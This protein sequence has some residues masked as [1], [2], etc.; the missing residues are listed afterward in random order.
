MRV[1]LSLA[2]AVAHSLSMTLATQPVHYWRFENTSAP[3]IDAQGTCDLTNGLKDYAPQSQDQDNNSVGNFIVFNYAERHLNAT[4]PGAWQ[5][6]GC[7]NDSPQGANGLTIEFLLHP[8]PWCFMRGGTMDL[9]RS[10]GGSVSVSMTYGGLSF[11]AATT[12]ATASPTH[13]VSFSGAGTL[14]SDHLWNYESTAGR[15][16]HFALARDASTGAIRI[17]IDGESQPTMRTTASE[18]TA[19]TMPTN[20]TALLVD[21]RSPVS[22]CAGLDELAVYDTALSVSYAPPFLPRVLA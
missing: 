15:W 18:P 21:W 12:N 11:T 5:A 16:H 4:R 7:V 10:E 6:K 17:F 9:L 2:I 22:L 1:L 3:L 19:A 20:D 13:T 8:T 14:S